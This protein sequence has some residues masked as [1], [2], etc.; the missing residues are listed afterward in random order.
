MKFKL[1]VIIALCSCAT[2]KMNNTDASRAK[3]TVAKTPGLPVILRVEQVPEDLKSL[4]RA[5]VIARGIDTIDL[6]EGIKI[7][8]EDWRKVN[9]SQGEAAANRLP[10]KCN[11]LRFAAVGNAESI[12]EISWKG[13]PMNPAN[14]SRPDTTTYYFT[15]PDSLRSEPARA[16]AACLELLLKS[17]ILQ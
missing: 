13:W 10:A 9:K 3:A 1:I 6:R 5:Q 4:F 8:R 12:S 16:I 15:T 7:A 14:G 2:T 11:M 17:R